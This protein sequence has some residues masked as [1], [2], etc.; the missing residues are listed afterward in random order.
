MDYVSVFQGHIYCYREML[1]AKSTVWLAYAG[2]NISHNLHSLSLYTITIP[3]QSFLFEVLTNTDD[4]LKTNSL[5]CSCRILLDDI[6]CK[7][8]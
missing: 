5:S 8:L 1:P 4:S 6:I 7:L 2:V 3:C